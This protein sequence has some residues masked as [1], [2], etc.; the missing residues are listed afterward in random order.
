M[1]LKIF[2]GVILPL[3]LIVFLTVLASWPSGF[4]T[5]KDFDEEIDFDVAFQ[6]SYSNNAVRIGEIK[7]DNDYFLPKRFD[8]PNYISCFYDEDKKRPLMTG[9]YVFYNEGEYSPNVKIL[10]LT[11]KASELA[12][13]RPYNYRNSNYKT[14]IEIGAHKSKILQI[15]YSSN[16]NY[17][18]YGGT[19]NPERDYDT[20]LLIETKG[21]EQLSCESL[22]SEEIQKAI[23]VKIIVPATFCSDSDDNNYNS[24]NNYDSVSNQELAQFGTCSDNTAVTYSDYC[25][26]SENIIEYTCSKSPE[27]KC[28]ISNASCKSYGYNR[29][30]NGRCS[31]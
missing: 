8:A 4:S 28:V 9:G 31:Y 18:G 15:Y 27:E 2:L 25:I 24:G 14:S 22:S 7:V 21:N 17:Y 5:N 3:V 23:K 1:K 29:C 26:D 13:Y 16:R 10:D 11:T 20:L 30:E 19:E 6:N 12:Y